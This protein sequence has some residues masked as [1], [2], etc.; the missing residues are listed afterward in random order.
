MPLKGVDEVNKR[1][2]E[3]MKESWDN[4][5]V[6]WWDTV[7]EHVFLPSQDQCPVKTGAMKSTGQNELIT[8]PHTI[9]CE[10]GY[11]SEATPYTIAQHERLDFHHEVGKA[12]FLEDPVNAAVPLLPQALIDRLG[13]KR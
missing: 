8:T 11:G 12:K 6:A 10:V 4:A 13:G 7:N 1:I 9:T 5:G 3:Y 2:K